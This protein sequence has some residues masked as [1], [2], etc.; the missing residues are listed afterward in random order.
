MV[1]IDL[2]ARAYCAPAGAERANRLGATDPEGNTASAAYVLVDLVPETPRNP[3]G[4]HA[5]P[6][7][8]LLTLAE[9]FGTVAVVIDRRAPRDGYQRRTAATATITEARWLADRPECARAATNHGL[10]GPGIG[11]AASEGGRCF[12]P[13]D[14]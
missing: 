8:D 4:L 10:A 13:R 2:K 1:D 5:Q 14:L 12:G 7:D 3:A 6:H 9:G 11:P